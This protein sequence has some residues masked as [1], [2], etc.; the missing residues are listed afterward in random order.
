[1]PYRD[2][3]HCK[4][5]F[6]TQHFWKVSI[7]RLVVVVFNEQESG[8]VLD[9]VGFRDKRTVGDFLAAVAVDAPYSAVSPLSMCFIS[10]APTW[11][12]RLT[13]APG[14]HTLHSRRMDG[15]PPFPAQRLER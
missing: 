5:Q 11:G 15:S 13:W 6:E 7:A 1:M 10:S 4:V 8:P 14:G 9:D 3:V 12:F 2:S